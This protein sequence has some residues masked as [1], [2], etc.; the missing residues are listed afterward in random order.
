VFK[1]NLCRGCKLGYHNGERDILKAKCR[2]KVC[3]LRREYHSCADCDEY[4]A[5]NTIQGLYAKKG[6]K[7]KK[8]REAT[9][10]IRANGYDRF[11]EIAD[12]WKGQY[13]KYR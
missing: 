7:Y 10:F 6:Y 8:Y 12:G 5:C 4:G 11:I 2:M 1:E 9:E 3:C 13:G